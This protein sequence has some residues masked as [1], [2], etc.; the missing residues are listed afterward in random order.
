MQLK[1]VLRAFSTRRPAS[2][3]ETHLRVVTGNRRGAGTHSNVYISFGDVNGNWTEQTYLGNDFPTASEFSSD[4]KVPENMTVAQIRIGH[5]NEGLGAGWFLERVTLQGDCETVVEFPCRNWI[6]EA[7]SM[8]ESGPP[9]VVLVQKHKEK[10]DH[11]DFR[12]R[13]AVAGVP[14]HFKLK[15]EQTKC[16]L[17]SE[18]GFA[19]EDAYFRKTKGENIWIGVADGVYGWRDQG[20]D[21]GEFSRALMKSLLERLPDDPNK[22]MKLM[23]REAF[24]DVLSQNI[25]GSCT[26]CLMRINTVSHEMK[27][28][29]LGDSRVTIV[30]YNEKESHYHFFWS[31]EESEHEFGC[32]K[33]LGSQK[34]SS[35]PDDGEVT[36]VN[37]CRNDVLIAASD[38]LYDNVLGEEILEYLDQWY[39]SPP[40]R[41][42]IAI[43]ALVAKAYDNSVSPYTDTPYARSATENFGM[44][45]SGGKQDDISAIAVFCDE[46]KK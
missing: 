37:L 40:R 13:S 42:D 43:R 30:R 2:K 15:E 7:D 27:V 35:H 44:I 24:D 31:S 34:F 38:G 33:Q 16:K 45:Y 29:V 36:Y 22:R 26:V 41:I 39:V 20:I 32:P 10:E 21:P 3:K 18:F 12:C 17:G 25:Q 5:D 6:G 23:I 46:P 4:V 9:E 19:G 11:R 14:A 28:Y 1:R 8:G